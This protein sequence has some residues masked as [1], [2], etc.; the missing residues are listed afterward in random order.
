MIARESISV[1]LTVW[2]SSVFFAGLVLFGAVM[3]FSLDH[4]LT[5]GRSHTLERRAAR[6]AQ[7]LDE[8]RP[9]PPAQRTRQI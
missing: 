2:F 1:R 5:A 4:T 7:L 6:L 8:T 9:D 3:W